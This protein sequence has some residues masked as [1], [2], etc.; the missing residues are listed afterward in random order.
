MGG[1][2][3]ASLPSHVN[4]FYKTSRKLHRAISVLGGGLATTDCSE[5]R[6]DG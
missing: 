6:R 4:I 3:L 1:V 5:T 2:C